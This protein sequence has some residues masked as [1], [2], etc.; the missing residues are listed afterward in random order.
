MTWT[1][2]RAGFCFCYVFVFVCAAPLRDQSECEHSKIWAT[3]NWS[4]SNC[5]M[6]LSVVGY[7]GRNQITQ[8]ITNTMDLDVN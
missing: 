5:N 4:G 8:I 7:P 6:A 1:L 2:P 3:P